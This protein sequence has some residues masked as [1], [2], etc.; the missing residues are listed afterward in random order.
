MSFQ[1]DPSLQTALVI[2]LCGEGERTSRD[3]SECPREGARPE[4]GDPQASSTGGIPKG[5]LQRRLAE[6]GTRVA[7]GKGLPQGDLGS[8]SCREPKLVSG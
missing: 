6:G 1:T 8:T 5:R 3:P 2:T 7:A 4:A